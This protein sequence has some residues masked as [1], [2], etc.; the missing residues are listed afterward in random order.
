MKPGLAQTKKNIV[1]QNIFQ[2]PLL[3]CGIFSSIW[4]FVINVIAPVKYP[5]YSVISQTVS[6]LSA[7]DT[8]TRTLWVIL[9]IFY[10]LLLVA[11][12][13]GVWLSGNGNKKLKLAGIVIIFDAIFGS[14]W[15]PMHQ[16]EV[17]AAGEATLTDTLHII[18]TFIHLILVVMMILFGALAMEKRF[19]IYSIAT[20]IIF[21]V[22]GILTSMESPHIEAG[23]PT[24]YIGIWERVNM[25]AYMIWII[26][27]AETLLQR[28]GIKWGS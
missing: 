7:I 15:P 24:P 21:F 10:T 22:F 13:S 1:H 11:F 20:I 9:C 12:G 28:T 17:I 27:F 23:T 5:G 2:K 18:W 26:V 3:Y 16:R 4:Y 19:R 8:P 25:A 6:E 14:F